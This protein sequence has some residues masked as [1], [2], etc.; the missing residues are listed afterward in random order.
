MGLHLSQ[1]ARRVVDIAFCAVGFGVVW[2][3]FHE[4]AVGIIDVVPK[5]FAFFRGQQLVGG[6]VLITGHCTPALS[7]W[8]HRRN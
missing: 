7:R 2:Q 1:V 6:I 5:G 4:I 3:D 8:D